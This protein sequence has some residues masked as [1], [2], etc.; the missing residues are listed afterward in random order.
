MRDNQKSKAQLIKDLSTLRKQVRE[1]EDLQVERSQVEEKLRESEEKYRLLFAA[2]QDAIVIVD[3]ESQRIVDT[4]DAALAQYGYTK[5]EFI[6]LKALDL[7]A[8]PEK[9]T[10]KISKLAKIG[11][12]T[13]QS[14]LL[15]HKRKDGTV[16][17]VEVSS[18]TFILRDRKM[19][20]AVFRDITKRKQAE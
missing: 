11:K 2:E 10:V 4:N 17:P 16:F 15:N 1:F 13:V 3:I 7:S 20:N 9:S 18:G 5:K 8:E 6:G 14:D 19:I 12:G